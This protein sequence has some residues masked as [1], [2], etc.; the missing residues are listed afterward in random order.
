MKQDSKHYLDESVK[1]NFESS[2]T[3]IEITELFKII[4]RVVESNDA[5]SAHFSGLTFMQIDPSTIHLR[6]NYSIGTDEI[7]KLSSQERDELPHMIGRFTNHLFA[8]I[9]STFKLINCSLP[10][11]FRVYKDLSEN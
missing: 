9:D 2:L 8:V 5:R 3:P 4:L 10:D 1:A 7:A 11:S 6:L